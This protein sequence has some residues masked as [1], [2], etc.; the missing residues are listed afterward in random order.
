MEIKDRLEFV[1]FSIGRYDHLYDAI[2]NKGNVFLALMTFLLGG[3]VTAFFT[4]H[5]DKPIEQSAWFFFA[6]IILVQLVGISIVLLSLK[7]YLKSGPMSADVS[8][9]FFSDTATIDS[10]TYKKLVKDSTIDTL[11]DDAYGQA[12]QLAKGLRFKY[13]LLN[14][15]TY[16]IGVQI[17][18]MVFL[19]LL[20]IKKP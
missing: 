5:H 6:T 11:L 15:V 1:K 4:I 8:V 12:Y 3:N 10:L 18:A 2:N 17:V 20:I 19:G 7:P 16:I 13:R 9:L 14:T